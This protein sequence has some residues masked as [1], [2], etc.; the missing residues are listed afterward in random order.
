MCGR[1]TAC[2]QGPGLQSRRYTL[3]AALGTHLCGRALT[4]NAYSPVQFKH[5]H[6]GGG[7]HSFKLPLKKSAVPL[8]SFQRSLSPIYNILT[9][10]SKWF[11]SLKPVRSLTVLSIPVFFFFWFCFV[12]FLFLVFINA[13]R[14]EETVQL[15]HLSSIYGANGKHMLQPHSWLC[16]SPNAQT[17]TEM[18]RETRQYSPTQSL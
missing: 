1:T 11:K 6:G 12:L 8:Q 7:G 2:V 13:R 5:E 10:S 4:Y 18:V 14:K 3:N 16:T 9:M 15:V 17:E